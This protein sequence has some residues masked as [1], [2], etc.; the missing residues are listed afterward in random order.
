MD[1]TV[2]QT[3]KLK[4]IILVECTSTLKLIK[5]N[6]ELNQKDEQRQFEV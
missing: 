2:K 6:V 5:K 3:T 4:N 1:S